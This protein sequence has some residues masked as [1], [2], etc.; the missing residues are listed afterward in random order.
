[1]IGIIERYE[2]PIKDL[3]K[4]RLLANELIEGNGIRR[5]TYKDLLID[6]QSDADDTV[7]DCRTLQTVLYQYATDF[8]ITHIDIVRP[9][10]SNLLL[11]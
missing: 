3:I 5:I 6:I 11:P 9:L 10:D 8:P 7:L 2:K 4:G 1:M